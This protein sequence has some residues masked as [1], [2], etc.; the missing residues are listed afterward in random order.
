MPEHSVSSAVQ[1]VSILVKPRAKHNRI[2]IDSDGR[3]TVAV[4]SPPVDGK[5]NAHVVKLLAGA[6][7]V[8]RA[9]VH[10]VRGVGS[11]H[12]MVVVDGLTP[13]EIAAKIGE[14]GSEAGKK[15]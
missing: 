4:T 12:K 13:A 1:A 14:R 5:A 9:S 2:C 11:K 3:L 6:L 10:I 8:S 15:E 7:M